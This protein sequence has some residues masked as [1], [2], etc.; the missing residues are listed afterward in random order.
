MISFLYQIVRNIL[1]IGGFIILR[2]ALSVFRPYVLQ[3]R[4]SNERIAIIEESNA[5]TMFTRELS[6]NGPIEES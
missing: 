3:L 1:L 6:A 2:V 5:L 4:G